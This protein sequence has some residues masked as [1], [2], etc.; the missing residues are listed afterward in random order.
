MLNQRN[1]IVYDDKS[2][3][4]NTI[5][6]VWEYGMYEE[7]GFPFIYNFSFRECK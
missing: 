4:Y 3:N 7:S 2:N 6:P 5:K 1:A